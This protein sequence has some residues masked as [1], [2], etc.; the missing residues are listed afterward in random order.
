[1]TPA[2]TSEASDLRDEQEV[3][4]IAV[5]AYIYL[6]PLVSRG[7]YNT[8]AE[9]WNGSSFQVVSTPNVNGTRFDNW[10]S[11]ASS[12]GTTVWSVG[13][14]GTHHGIHTLAEYVC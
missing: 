2:T 9:K 6:Y 3:Q 4:V 11:R 1:V 8:V 7:P 14:H 5:E 10:L 13:H 12:D